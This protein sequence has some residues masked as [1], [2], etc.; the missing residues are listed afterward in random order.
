MQTCMYVCLSS[1][2]CMHVCSRIGREITSR[3]LVRIHTCMYVWVWDVSAHMYVCMYVSGSWACM[4]VL[5]KHTS[6][7]IHFDSSGSTKNRPMLIWPKNV[8]FPLKISRSALTKS[9]PWFFENLASNSVCM[10]VCLSPQACMHACL[11]PSSVYVC[12]FELPGVH[13]CMF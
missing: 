12:M 13:A 2:A 5:A 9:P 6:Q 4:Y 8:S 11:K 7:T 3:S 1:Q 10:Y